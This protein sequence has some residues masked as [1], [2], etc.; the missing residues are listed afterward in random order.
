M[1]RRMPIG[2][3]YVSGKCTINKQEADLVKRMF[4]MFIS[5]QSYSQIALEMQ[6][7]FP[8]EHFDKA[9]IG[10]VLTDPRYLGTEKYDRIIDDDVFKKASSLR[11]VKRTLPT[12]DK[13]AE[14]L[15][16]RLPVICP[17][18]GSCMMRKQMLKSDKQNWTC[19]SKSC[20]MFIRK[21][22]AAFIEELKDILYELSLAP[23]EYEDD[24]IQK[25]I[26]TALLERKIEE[27][28]SKES[29]DKEQI[30]KDITELV[31][32]KYMDITNTGYIQK[33]IAEALEDYDESHYLETVNEIGIKIEFNKDDAITFVLRD[34]HGYRRMEHHAERRKDNTVYC[35][36]QAN[37]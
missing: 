35:A 19:T 31:G 11:I 15:G 18:C 8:E 32:K 25:G 6:I 22:D 5:G 3:L 20:D 33:K 36:N 4:E 30:T 23:Y 7:Y 12:P 1:N 34:D 2:Y 24:H 26:N 28:L 27:Q 13:R 37:S 14:I 16:M 21:N 9:K 17:K 10:R 29:F